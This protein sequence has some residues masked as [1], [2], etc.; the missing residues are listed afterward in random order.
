MF[1]KNEKMNSRQ[2]R[3]LIEIG[4]AVF[5]FIGGF[6]FRTRL[7]STPFGI[8]EYAVFL[9]AFLIAGYE[10]L[11]LA[12]KNI[13]R[14][15]IF[16]EHLLMSLATIVAIVIAALPE[17][18]GVMIFYK[19]GV[20]LEQ[21]SVKKSR[22]SI[23]SLLELK[24]TYAN[25]EKNG[26]HERVEPKEVRIGDV[27]LVKPGEKVP[28]DGIV[29]TGTAQV[30]TT[31]LTGESIP[32]K[33][34]AGDQ[35]LSGMHVASGSLRME[36][37]RSYQDSSI[38]RIVHMV[39]HA[40]DNKTK[41]E[42]FITTFSKYYTPGIVVLALCVAI[43]PP[44]LLHTATF[45]DWIYRALVMLVVSCPCALM[46]SI[47][48][49]YFGGIGG[50][51][52]KGILVKG[53]SFIDGLSKTRTVVFDK[54]GTLT[55]GSFNVLEVVSKNG[56]AREDI[57][58]YAACAE[59]HSNHPIAQ[60]IRDHF[61]GT[62]EPS[63]VTSYEEISGFGIMAEVDNRLVF[64]GNDRMLHKEGIDHDTC[65]L[66]QTAAHVVIDRVYAGYIIIGD[67]L[68]QDAPVAIDELKAL[69]T[70]KT[71]MLTGDNRQVAGYVAGSLGI[72]SY[73]AELLPEDKVKK[74]VE[75]KSSL[76]KSEKVVFVGDGINDA[77]VIAQSDIGIAMGKFGSDIAID[78]ADVVLM[79]DSPSKVAEAIR[80]SKKTRI[81]V[82]QNIVLALGIKFIFVVLG[83]AGFANM[84]EA[85][86]G[87]VGVTLIAILN[88]LRAL[89]S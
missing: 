15:K 33:I 79:T 32:R 40:A 58:F 27:I 75:I 86:F 46:I 5:L 19:I 81:I 37:S 21:L 76:K 57:L 1:W 16:N 56:H 80:L 41:T 51:S 22:N 18:V 10:V 53:S 12:A 39:E 85:V 30:D 64:V 74:L 73:H 8:A 87:D 11:L 2:K 14:G 62:V 36:V 24:P 9:A 26:K 31:A 28:L 42:K 83:I 77:P 54:T 50:A 89:R 17:A 48:L 65:E 63:A 69:S 55:K 82:Y 68:K 66:K 49:G 6:V 29:L 72:D 23:Q 60:S 13:L 88:S 4:A 38:Q 3:E 34:E 67:E 52:K 45:H 78:S 20:F 70:I 25:L 59:S 84:W 47:P 71:V 43:L 7:H 61:E 35:I 44:L